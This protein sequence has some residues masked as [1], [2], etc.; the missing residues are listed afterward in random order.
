MQFG[1][2]SQSSFE[3][4]LKPVKRLSTIFIPVPLRAPDRRQ[5]EARFPFP[6]AVGEP[7]AARGISNS[8]QESSPGR[9]TTGRGLPTD[10]TM[11]GIDPRDQH[12]AL[13]EDEDFDVL[14]HC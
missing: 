1:K 3:L 7:V 8:A 2:R 9:V 12:A 6:S 14:M 4:V 11:I 13:E 10:A 5:N